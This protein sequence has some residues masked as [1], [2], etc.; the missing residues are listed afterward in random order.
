MLMVCQNKMR[1]PIEIEKQLR[2]VSN[3]ETLIGIV[4]I[5]MR[6]LNLSFREVLELPLPTTFKLLK[7]IEKENKE[8]K[9]AMRKR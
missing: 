3:S 4:Y 5:L 6:E 1:F 2:R 7:R 9:R 8:L